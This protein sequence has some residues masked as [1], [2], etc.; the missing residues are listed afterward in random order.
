MLAYGLDCSV[1]V[2][3]KGHIHGV[4]QV[5]PLR[6]VNPSHDTPG[7]SFQ[8]TGIGVGGVSLGY[9]SPQLVPSTCSGR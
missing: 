8:Q 3:C 4:H 1:P 7:S 2:F 5:H 9:Y 6:V